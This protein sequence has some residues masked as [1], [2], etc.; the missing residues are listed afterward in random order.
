MGARTK[1]NP[2]LGQFHYYGNTKKPQA[3]RDQQP[4]DRVSWRR[5]RLSEAAEA[6]AGLEEVTRVT[7]FVRLA[8]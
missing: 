5:I 6:C 1:L 7:A 2:S 3:N 8:R 4:E